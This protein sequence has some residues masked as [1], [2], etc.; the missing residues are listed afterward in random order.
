M[1]KC[2]DC[3]SFCLLAR[4]FPELRLKAFGEHEGRAIRIESGFEGPSIAEYCCTATDDQRHVEKIEE[5]EE[6]G[7]EEGHVVPN[8][9]TWRYEGLCGGEFLTRAIGPGVP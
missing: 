4:L 3:N 9:K 6:E 2:C 1:S 8:L 5:G 7:R